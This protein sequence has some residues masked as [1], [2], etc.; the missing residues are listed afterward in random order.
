M[1]CVI[2]CS[3]ETDIERKRGMFVCTFLDI[4]EYVVMIQRN[5]D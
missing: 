2:N 1:R 4:N 3:D 5:S